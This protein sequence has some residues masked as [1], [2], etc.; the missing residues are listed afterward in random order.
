MKWFPIFI[1]I[2]VVAASSAMNTMA[3]ET[4]DDGAVFQWPSFTNHH[5]ASASFIKRVQC[6]ASIHSVYSCLRSSIPNHHHHKLLHGATDCC[7]TIADFRTKCSDFG[8]RKLESFIFPAM[9]FKQ[10]SA[11]A[12]AS[13]PADGPAADIY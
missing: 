5:H 13:P 2:V 3:D 9:L 10:C 12:P 6:S 11:A 4:T 7:T 1:C 8:V